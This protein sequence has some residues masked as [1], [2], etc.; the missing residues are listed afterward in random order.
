MR[1]ETHLGLWLALALLPGTSHAAPVAE[2]LTIRNV[3]AKM[4]PGINLGNTLEAIPK[5]TSWGNPVP[6]RAYMV[7]VRKAGFKSIRIPIA[8]TQYLDAKSQIDPKWM[9]HITSIVKDAEDAGLYVLINVHWDGGWQQPTYAKQKAVNEKLKT[10]W[11]QIAHNFRDFDDRLLFAGTN[12]IGIDGYYGPPKPENVVVQNGFNQ[13]F[14]NTV[15]ATG[16]R[17]QNRLLVIQG[18]GT[19][20]DASTKNNTTLPTDSAKNAL[21]MEVHY[22]SPYNFT[23][24]DKS[25]I[26][27]WGHT[28]TDPA[29]T[30]TWANEEY[31]DAEFQKVTSAFV[32]RG[33]PV[34]LGEYASGMKPQF[35]GM[36]KYRILWDEA[37][38][39]AAVRHGMIPMYWDTGGLIDR[40]TGAVKD[41]KAIRA[42]VG[43]TR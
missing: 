4:S 20:I 34:I 8:W 36:D 16:G 40:T 42:I 29:A 30:E 13:V 26:W 15:R 1:K 28:A 41:P 17:N 9:S 31:L 3:T 35:P 32:D 22:Y 12:E 21:L 38:T 37:V 33:V 23:L 6:N 39:H 18:Y 27:Q 5:E 14:V 24:N 7:A 19:D 25:K 43:A 10:L 11:V 2:A